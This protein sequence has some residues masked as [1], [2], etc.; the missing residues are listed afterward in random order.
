MA[1]ANGRRVPRPPVRAAVEGRA[2][3][4][5]RRGHGRRLRDRLPA[6]A[7]GAPRPQR[8]RPRPLRRRQ[9]RRLRHLAPRQRDLAREMYDALHVAPSAAR[10]ACPTRALFRLGLGEFLRAPGARPRVLADAL[11]GGLAGEGPQPGATWPGPCSSSSP[12]GS[13][14]TPGSR[15][16]SRASSPRAGA[17]RLSTTC[18]RPLLRRRGGPRQRRG[19]RLRTGRRHLGHGVE[20]RPGLYRPAR[21]LSPRAHRRPRLRGRRPSRRRRTSTSPSSAGPTSSSA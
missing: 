1:Q 13:S 21:P 9:R 14:T 7:R 11:L 19:R 16:T 8:D 18:A 15:N 4:R 3:L 5:G 6:R 17:N 2:R 20:G 12:P 10:W